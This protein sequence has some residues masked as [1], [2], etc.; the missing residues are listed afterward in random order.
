M[1]GRRP[2]DGDDR[3]AAQ[4]SSLPDLTAAELEDLL[5]REDRLVLVDFWTARCEPCRELMRRLAAL[6]EE[7]GDVCMVVAVDADREPDAVARH[8]VR[9]FPTLVFFKRGL[10][11]HRLKGGALPA[12]TLAL[13]GG[14]PQEA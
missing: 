13:L 2:G 6:A 9:D 10:E 7:Q 11:L 3:R 4:L 14:P 12:S 5:G 1:R 8:G